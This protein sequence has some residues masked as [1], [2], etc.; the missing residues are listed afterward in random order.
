MADPQATPTPEAIVAVAP[1][2]TLPPTTVRGSNMDERDAAETVRQFGSAVTRGDEV[3]ALLVLSPSAQQ[4]VAA[5]NLYVFLGNPARPDAFT[6]GAVQLDDDVAVV[7]CTLQYA[8]STHALRLQLVRLEG[9]WKIDAR[10][11]NE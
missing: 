5:S 4:I 3:V 9:V 8:G 7:E 6:I 10:V 11:V 1:M 2:P